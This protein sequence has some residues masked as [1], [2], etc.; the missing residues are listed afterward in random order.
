MAAILDFLLL[1]TSEL[2]EIA[3][4]SWW[5]S[6]IW[7]L[8]LEFRRNLVN[9]L[10]YGHFRFSSRHLGIQLQGRHF[11]LFKWK[12]KSEDVEPCP[13]AWTPS[14]T[15]V[16]NMASNWNCHEGHD[17]HKNHEFSIWGP[18]VFQVLWPL[19]VWK[20]PIRTQSASKHPE[21][22][23]WGIG[24]S[25]L[26]SSY[27]SQRYSKKSRG[28]NFAPPAIRGLNEFSRLVVTWHTIF[29]HSRPTTGIKNGRL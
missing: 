19:Q 15:W 16:S 5:P 12:M 10:R 3:L 6:I 9:R 21:L 23:P 25:A 4:L 20:R 7:G 27:G 18:L 29:G 22:C 24:E 1:A 11:W 14:K 13:L 26:L 8:P 17:R 2:L 28:C